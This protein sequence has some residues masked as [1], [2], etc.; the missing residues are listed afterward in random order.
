MFNVYRGIYG[1]A[2][3][4]LVKWFRDWNPDGIIA[5]IY[6][7]RLAR[8]YRQAGKPVVE[9]FE[10]RATSEFARILPDDVATGEM[11]AKHFLERGFRHFGFFGVSWMLWSREREVGFRL[12][13]ERVFRGRAEAAGDA[14]IAK[15]FSFSS[16]GTGESA[17][18]SRSK[19]LRLNAVRRR[20]ARG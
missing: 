10:S 9:L 20:W 16:Y 14:S 17:M 13:I 19:A 6:D 12:E 8:V 18:R 1:H 5:Q 15:A 11:A 4:Y 2:S 3:K 7:D